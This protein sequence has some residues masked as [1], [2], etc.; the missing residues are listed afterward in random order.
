VAPR[1]TDY[2]MERTTSESQKTDEPVAPGRRDN[3]Y[4]P[5]EDDGDERGRYAGRVSGHSLY[6]HAALHPRETLLAASA[7]GL[8]LAVGWR[9]SRRRGG[10]VIPSG[11]HRD[12]LHAGDTAPVDTRSSHREERGTHAGIRGSPRLSQTPVA[13]AIDAAPE[14]RA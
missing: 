4:E 13:A 9:A 5:V 1:L 3:L 12:A 6:T 7:L 10:G 2:Y 11:D 8:A 14:A